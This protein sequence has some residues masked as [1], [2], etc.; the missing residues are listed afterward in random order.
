MFGAPNTVKIRRILML[1]ETFG[2][3]NRKSKICRH[4]KS[5]F[6]NA[7]E[8]STIFRAAKFSILHVSCSRVH[9]EILELLYKQKRR[10]SACVKEEFLIEKLEGKIDNSKLKIHVDYL[11]K[12]GHIIIKP[13]YDGF[14]TIKKI[15]ITAKGLDLFENQN[16]SI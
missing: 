8:K 2:F 11:E 9:L 7:V 16:A 3:L 6:S 15:T 12:K 13:V 5:R 1:R 14:V 4:R 10:C